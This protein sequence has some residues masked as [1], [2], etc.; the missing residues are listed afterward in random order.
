[1]AFLFIK[2]IK[3][4]GNPFEIAPLM[5]HSFVCS[6]SNWLHIFRICNDTICVQCSFA[7][8]SPYSRFNWTQC[9]GNQWPRLEHSPVTATRSPGSNLWLTKTRNV[10]N[11]PIF[12]TGLRSFIEAWLVVSPAVDASLLALSNSQCCMI[13]LFE[14]YAL[15]FTQQFIFSFSPSHLTFIYTCNLSWQFV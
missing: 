12:P 1:M 2:L 15:F 14:I 10:C 8:N 3:F 7:Y 4:R 9:A 11:R 5:S 13:N 6:G